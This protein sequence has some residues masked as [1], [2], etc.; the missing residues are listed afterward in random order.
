MA[1]IRLKEQQRNRTRPAHPT[2]ANIK[3]SDGTLDDVDY[4]LDTDDNGF[5]LTGVN[6]DPEKRS[7][8]FIGGSFV[9]SSFAQPHQRFVA[10]VAQNVDWNVYNAGYSGMTLLQACVMIMTKIPTLAKK[11]DVIVLF[12]AQ[13]DANASRL[14]GG[15]WTNNS[16]YTAIR[17]AA[18]QAPKWQFS[19]GDTR[20][21]LESITTF[22]R[23]LGL[24]IVLVTSPYRYLSWETDK[25]SRL[26]FGNKRVLGEYQKARAELT[27]TY[28]ETAQLREIPLLDLEQ[29][30]S[31]DPSLFYDELHFNTAGH[32]KAGKIITEYLK[33]H[34]GS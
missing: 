7:L 23:G 19:F 32:E 12:T 24:D 29:I 15:Y 20:A 27:N 28:R 13:S 2:K 6:T 3:R 5:I 18:A 22:V 1:R 9:E 30:I 25:W 26:N 16:T 21:L 11:H 17:P 33:D 14:P 34:L 31:G 4:P 10:R 8:F